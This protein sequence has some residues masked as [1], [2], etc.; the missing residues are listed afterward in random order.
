MK[1]EERKGCVIFILTPNFGFGFSL[2]L[3][4]ETFAESLNGSM[5]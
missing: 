1:E 2:P 4:V 5:G 3:V